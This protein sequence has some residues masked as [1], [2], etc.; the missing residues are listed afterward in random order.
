MKVLAIGDIMG[1]PG[2]KALELGLSTVRERFQPD[3]I[4]ANGENAAGGFGLTEKVFLELTEKN[5]ITCV[6]MGNH[7]RDKPEIESFFRKYPNLVLPGNMGNVPGLEHGLR[8]LKMPAG[9]SYAV[10]NLIGTTF[11]KEGNS[12][13]FHAADQLLARIPSYVKTIIVDLH[14]EATSEKQA[15]AHYLAGRV[16]LIYGTHTHTQTADERLLMRHTGYITDIGMSGP[17]DSVIGVKKNL[18]LARFLDPKNKPKFEPAKHDLWFCAIYCEI[19]DD[20]GSCK[21]I[22]RVQIR[23]PDDDENSKKDPL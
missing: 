9:K 18:S 13:A 17:Y 16:S 20:T 3:V 10:I 8:I 23:F 4:L 19:E 5:G 12:N 14:A 7:W 15:F 22:E 21:H 6:T 1:K 11:M 2:R